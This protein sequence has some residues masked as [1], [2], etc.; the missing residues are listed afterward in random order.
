VTA[1]LPLDEDAPL[2]PPQIQTL[3]LH[4]LQL[5]MTRDMGE[6]ADGVWTTAKV[7]CWTD[8]HSGRILAALRAY[9]LAGPK[10]HLGFE[11]EFSVPASWWDAF[12]FEVLCPRA[13]GMSLR[14]QVLRWWLDRHLVKW[15]TVT[16]RGSAECYARSCPHISFPHEDRDVHIRF[17]AGLDTEP[18]QKAERDAVQERFRYQ[19]QFRSSMQGLRELERER[20]AY[21]AELQWAEWERE[22]KR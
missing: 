13:K 10:Q 19:N 12:K 11:E 9:V 4:K 8:M 17:A 18:E 15:R 21:F 1:L 20:P 5:A 6:P 3:I 2:T 7:K 16:V 14:A 22:R